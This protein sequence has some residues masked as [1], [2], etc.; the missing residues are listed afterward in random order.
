MTID[1]RT[2]CLGILRSGDATG[3]EIQ[4]QFKEGP[5]GHFMEASYGSIYPALTRLTD[6]G[7][8]T[9]REEIQD[10]KPDKKVYSI[11]AQGQ[12][13]LADALTQDPAID[14]FRS[15]FLFFMSMAD[16][17]SNEH[18]TALIDN[19]LGEAKDMLR[20]LAESDE[21]KSLGMKFVHEYGRAMH[22]ASQDFLEQHRDMIEGR[23]EPPHSEAAE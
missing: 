10:G 8:V 7:L 21:D 2:M 13:A 3:Y 22:Q 16:L 18:L 1:V 15:E 17:L 11:S 23:S 14:K 6:D 9:C 5:F 19:R 12:A 20:T 4:K